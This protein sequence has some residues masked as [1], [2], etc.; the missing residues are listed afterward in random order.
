MP[1]QLNPETTAILALDF[2]NDIVGAT[3]GVAPVLAQARRLLEAGRQLRIP[4]LYIKVSFA[5]GYKDA[6]PKAPLFQGARQKGILRAGTPGTEIHEQ[7][8][9]LPG[10]PVLNKTC[11][12][13]FLTTN[14]QQRLH[15]LG[16]STVIVMGLWTNYVVESTTRHAADMGYEVIVVRDACASNIRE[17]H[18][19]TLKNILPAFATVCDTHDVLEALGVKNDGFWKSTLFEEADLAARGSTVQRVV[20]KPG[21][22]VQDH[23]HNKTTEVYCVVRGSARLFIDGSERLARPGDV[24]IAKPGQRHSLEP[25]GA[26]ELELVMFTTNQEPSDVLAS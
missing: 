17:N 7:V 11:V 18:D 3:P 26:E 6:P 22:G 14:L 16:A 24:F 2:E 15:L 12:N 21:T 4:I 10:E 23:V 25:L 9:P 19:F 13:P 8:R 20:V 1:L 5:E